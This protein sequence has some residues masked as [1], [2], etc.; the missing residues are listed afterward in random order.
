MILAPF[1]PVFKFEVA[2]FPMIPL[3]LG[4]LGPQRHLNTV[5]ILLIPGNKGVSALMSMAAH[6]TF[7]EIAT[8]LYEM[9]HRG[10]DQVLPA[11][12]AN[13]T[14]FLQNQHVNILYFESLELI[15]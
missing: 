12:D 13:L 2:I 15:N 10:M 7:G 3:P 4:R 5:T 6:H 8:C 1:F 9:F 14:M 11:F